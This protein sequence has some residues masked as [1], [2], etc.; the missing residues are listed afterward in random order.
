VLARVHLEQVSAR[1][2]DGR[3]D[4]VIGAKTVTAGERTEAAAQQ[5]SDDAHAR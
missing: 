3:A 2:D 5:K 4:Q 1:G